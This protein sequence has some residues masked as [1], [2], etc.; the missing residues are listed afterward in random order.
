M[1]NNTISFFEEKINTFDAALIELRNGSYVRGL[2]K[3]NMK[4]EYYRRYRYIISEFKTTLQSKFL[5]EETEMYNKLKIDLE[6]IKT[7]KKEDYIVEDD[8]GNTINTCVVNI[9]YNKGI[10]ILKEMETMLRNIVERLS[11]K[12]RTH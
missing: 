3:A 6:T 10:Y 8:L 9:D 7:K 1:E 11:T 12:T 2:T 4:K 5:K